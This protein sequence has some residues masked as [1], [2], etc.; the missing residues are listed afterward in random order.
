VK[1]ELDDRLEA[2]GPD[3]WDR[4]H[5]A[6]GLG[7]PFLSWTWQSEWLRAFAADR[8]LELR[9]VTDRDGG[10]LALLPLV[11]ESPGRLALVGGAEVSDYLD[12][13]AVRGREEEAWT[14]LL[15]ARAAS[16]DQ[17]VLHAV[18]AASPTIAVLP[19]VARACGL[20]VTARVEE[21][22]P[23]LDL[24]PTW[25]A[26]WEGLPGKHRHELGRKARRL[27]REAP[28]ARASVAST[29]G[30][31]A[32]R[33]GDFLRLHR[34]SRTGKAKFMDATMEGFFRATLGALAARGQAR[35]WFLDLPDG[36]I[37]AF[38]TL[39]WGDTVGLYNSGFAPGR[40]ALA[41]GLVLLTDVLRDAIVR[42]RRRFDFLRGEERYKYE[43][44]PSPE[45]V[46]LVRI[47][48]A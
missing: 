6:S 12:L 5:A 26:Y 46:H 11:E 20:A 17:W 10:L 33:L 36:P 41:P 39:E 30:D 29:P 19:T 14:A 8:R 38:V 13:L 25:D 18:P 16:R 48:P 44:G 3:A 15:G 27:A 21:R 40:A 23:V 9:R 47:G 7:V 42:G 28:G 4:L 35:L 45:D 34:A 22:C 24:P 32:A 43:F 37:A 2:V 1:V 31:V